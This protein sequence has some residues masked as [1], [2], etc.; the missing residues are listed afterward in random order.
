MEDIHPESLGAGPPSNSPVATVP[1]MQRDRQSF[2]WS[3]VH[4]S[5]ESCVP[6]PRSGAASVVV[7]GKLYMFGVSQVITSRF[8]DYL[9][10]S[11]TYR[12]ERLTLFCP[13]CER[14]M[15]VALDV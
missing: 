1:R 4:L 11:E 14:D 6:P 15:A 12:K 3:R 2:L 5:H 13:F 7:Q 9:D 8:A 10:A